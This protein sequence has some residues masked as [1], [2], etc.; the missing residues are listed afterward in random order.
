MSRE[1]AIALLKKSDSHIFVIGRTGAGKS[2]L[3]K[4][5][6]IPN[7]KYFDFVEFNEYMNYSCML[8]EDNFDIFESV[9]LNASVENLILD[10][11]EFP[12]N[13]EESR[14]FHFIKTARKHGKR[15]I[16]AVFPQNADPILCNFSMVNSGLL[17]AI[18]HLEKDHER[19][20]FMCDVER[21]SFP[22]AEDM[23]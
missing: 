7:S 3:L 5:A 18:I 10:A 9:L 12:V 20:D 23:K 22:D 16:I 6:K 11:V 13:L 8:C 1:L 19:N 15:L 21:I 17:S 14:L 2:Q 4:D